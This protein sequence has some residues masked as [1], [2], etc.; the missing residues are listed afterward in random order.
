MLFLET[1][2]SPSAR[3]KRLLIPSCGIPATMPRAHRIQA[4]IRRS[5]APLSASCDPEAQSVI[6]AGLFSQPK[7]NFV[8]SAQEGFKNGAGTAS[9]PQNSVLL[10]PYGDEAVPAP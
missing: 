1:A 9:S 6:S 3:Q 4:I 8:A 7:C 2:M 10:R 5:S